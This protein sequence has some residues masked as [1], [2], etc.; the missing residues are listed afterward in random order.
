MVPIGFYCDPDGI[1]QNAMDQLQQYAKREHITAIRAFTDIHYCAE[2]ALP[3][4]VAFKT[5]DHVYPLITGKDIG[6]G[7]MY[8]RIG[9]EN[10]IKPF[11]KNEHFRALEFTHQKMT[12]DGLGGGNH[13]LSIEEDDNA[14]YI[15]CHTG[16]RDRGIALYQQCLQLTRDYSRE[17]GRQVE[18]VHKDFLQQEFISYYNA[19]LQFGYERRKDFC[20]KTLIFLQNANYVTADKQA[21]RKDYLL[22]R[23]NQ[24]PDNGKLY[25]TPYRLEDSIHNH[26]RFNGNEILHRKGSTELMASKTVVV[27]FSMSRGSL[28]VQAAN[29]QEAAA[30]LHSCAHGAGR[31]L[32]RFDAMKYWK[33]VLKEKQRKQYREQFSE[34]LNRS[35]DFPHGYIQE[36]D[37]AYKDAS[38]L[39]AYQPYL[40]KVTQTRPVVTIKFTEI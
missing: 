7:V 3:V 18:Y 5:N 35:G 34:L 40:K 27:P 6:C 21:I 32:S 31:R 12:D 10:W 38:D 25:G 4:G 8:L 16:T 11:D 20:I 33:T 19:T 36:F 15:I 13:F 14:V 39:L 37:F 23:Y 17:S 30:A 9:K 2:K 29:G 24:L 26:I 1:E 28:L 22:A